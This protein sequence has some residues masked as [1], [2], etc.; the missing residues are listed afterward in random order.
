MIE[1]TDV[2]KTYTTRLGVITQALDSIDLALP[3]VGMIFVLGKSGSGKSTLLNLLG[4]LDRA[5]SGQ[6]LIDGDDLGSKS[7]EDLDA[8][9]CHDIGFVFQD[10]NIID[11]YSVREN[12]G[13]A[14][15]LQG[16]AIDHDRMEKTLATV[17]LSDFEQRK[18]NEVSGGQKQRIAIARA[19][20]KQPRL[21]LADEPTGNLDSETS[22]QIMELLKEVSK[23][24][25]V[26][27]VSH[28]PEEAKQFGDRILYI[29]DGRIAKDECIQEAVHKTSQ[30]NEHKGFLKLSSSFKYGIHALRPKRLQLG[31]TSLL[32][33]FSLMISSL[34]GAYLHFLG[35]PDTK[36]GDTL[37]SAEIQAI[38]ED[39][40]AYLT[41]ANAEVLI[42]GTYI[43]L[44]GIFYV[45]LSISVE[46]RIK[47][48][49][50]FK[51]IG[52]RHHDVL[53]IFVWEALLLGI[54]SF[55]LSSLM[56]YIYLLD[57]NRKFYDGLQVL[58]LYKP[59]IV[60]HGILS[61]ILPSL[62]IVGL[63]LNT[64][65]KNSVISIL[66]DS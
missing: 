55:V 35:D 56:A 6:I 13:I 18:G 27:V 16:K 49:G 48:M 3:E 24:T 4:G 43:L 23:D 66:K 63:T 1:L 64:L 52:A 61:L 58:I 37:K 2:T 21:I 59:Q 10:F 20:I 36:L 31:M 32:L 42:I 30:I 19:L 60:F 62:F 54:S 14:M 33:T 39:L 65:R 47:Q 7:G 28:D 25:L 38:V 45:F 51:A 5:D 50:I 26:V 11:H 53:K 29:K 22:N 17:G 34:L 40:Q 41:Q 9:R 57:I 12:V 46:Q 44:L 8:Y 15:E